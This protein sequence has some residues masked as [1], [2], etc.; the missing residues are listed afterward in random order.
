MKRIAVVALLFLI[1]AVAAFVMANPLSWGVTTSEHFSF[2]RFSRIER[3]MKIEEA[4][5]LLGRPVRVVDGISA[6]LC[7]PRSVCRNFI[8]A[9]GAKSWVVA[10]KKAWVI[11]DQHD[12]VVETLLYEEP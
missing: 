7:P 9:D 6:P 2:Q 10:Y 5:N 12:R 4:I 11:V 1:S 3:G 8:F